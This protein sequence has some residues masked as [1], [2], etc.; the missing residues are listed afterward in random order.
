MN[1]GSIVLVPFPF[2]DLQGTKQRPALVI[3]NK[4]FEGD[5]LIICA[6]TIQPS[7]QSLPISNQELKTNTLPADSYVKYGKIFTINKS[8]IRKTVATVQPNFLAQ[9]IQK[10]HAITQS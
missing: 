3:S 10:M 5:D 9:V 1:Q 4:S 2:S 7:K 6:L 8:I